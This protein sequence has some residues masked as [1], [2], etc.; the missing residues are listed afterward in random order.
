MLHTIG[1]GRRSVPELS[2][3][4][5]AAGV[6]L[7]V[8]VRHH[9]GSRRNPQLS[10]ERLAIELP[11]SAGIAYEW[12]GEE[13]GGRR[14][15]SADSRHSAWRNASF[16]AYA[17]HMQTPGFRQAFAALMERAVGEGVAVMCA[18]TLWWR[19]HRRLL[20]DA[21]VLQG[22]EVTHLLGQGRSTPHPLH[23][24]VRIDDDGWPVYDVEA[25][26]RL[27]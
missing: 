12:W 1:H 6:A 7:L 20:A 24:A 8:D 21:A 27:W 9:P 22:I 23:P 19:C 14:S 11:A 26:T 2:A 3:P 16:R 13:L 10:G 18:E 15:G 4:L 25:P 5:E 17:D